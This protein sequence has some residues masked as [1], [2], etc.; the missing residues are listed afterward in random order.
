MRRL[1]A[2]AVAIATVGA[3][4]LFAAP[5]HAADGRADNVRGEIT[6][7]LHH[8]MGRDASGPQPDHHTVEHYLPFAKKSCEWGVTD[9]TYRMATSEEARR[10]WNNN[11]QDLAGMLYAGLLDRAPD[12]EGLRTH[13]RTIR[14]YGL[15]WTTAQVLGSLEYRIR[16]AGICNKT[17]GLKA[18][19]YDWQTTHEY[20]TGVLLPAVISN[21]ASCLSTNKMK[22]IVDVREMSMEELKKPKALIKRNPFIVVTG[23]IASVY[24]DEVDGTCDSVKTLLK[25][26]ANIYAVMLDGGDN[27]NPVFIQL[28]RHRSIKSL[29]G[30]TYFSIRAG[31]NPTSW[32]VYEGNFAG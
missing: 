4:G 16:L 19:M 23:T 32:E 12:D 10:R 11:A 14:Q 24:H 1:L 6:A 28:D 15:K 2:T 27:H 30:Q 18:S 7:V 3:A 5:A 20:V 21:G 26:V 22:E 9:A 29:W 13:T 25:A 31:S 17:N 8:T